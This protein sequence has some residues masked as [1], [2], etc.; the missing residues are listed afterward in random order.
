M[1]GAAL[2]V[3]ALLPW[4]SLFAGLDRYRGVAGLYG[5]ILLVGGILAITGGVALLVRPA[6]RIRTALGLLGAVLAGLASWVLL[7]L[8]ATTG[9][10]RHHPLLLARPGPGP[11]VAFAG[12]LVV[13][14]LILP[15]RRRIARTP[16][17]RLTR[18]VEDDG[19]GI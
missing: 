16:K 15:P 17:G 14:A 10:L 18:D 11:F 5:R 19:H 1:G 12:G 3:G 4:M 8:R 6:H 13:A 9:A 2:V 7:G